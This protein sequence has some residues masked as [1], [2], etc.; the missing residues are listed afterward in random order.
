ML[1][2]CRGNLEVHVIEQLNLINDA[3]QLATSVGDELYPIRCLH[4]TFFH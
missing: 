2:C 4:H 1:A 3:I